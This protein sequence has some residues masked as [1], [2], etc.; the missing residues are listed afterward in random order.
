MK[1]IFNELDIEEKIFLK[2]K[3]KG[4]SGLVGKLAK[5]VN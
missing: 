5:P 2:K 1:L 4:I 3:K